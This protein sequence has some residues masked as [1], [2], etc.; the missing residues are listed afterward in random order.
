MTILRYILITS[1]FLMSITFSVLAFG[2]EEA[3]QEELTVTGSRISRPEISSNVPVTVLDRAD[4]ERTGL[5]NLGDI[6]R[7]TP[8]VQ[9]S[10]SNSNVSNGG[11]GTVKFS[12]RGIGPARTLILL[13]GR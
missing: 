8:L 6:L 5:S 7:S 12:L 10:V 4:I 2:Q 11:D 13:N 1:L 9:G 3:D